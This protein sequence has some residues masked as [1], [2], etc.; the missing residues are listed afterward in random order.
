MPTGRLN[1]LHVISAKRRTVRRPEG[2]SFRLLSDR[3]RR[4][5]AA[6]YGRPPLP[7]R[8]IERQARNERPMVATRRNGRRGQE[9]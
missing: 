3:L 4:S 8:L 6:T 5:Q 7:T 9:L 1:L 2:R